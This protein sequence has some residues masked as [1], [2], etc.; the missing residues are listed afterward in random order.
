MT[1]SFPVASQVDYYGAPTPIRQLAGISVPESSSLV[2]QPYDKGSMQAIEKAIQMSDLGLPPN[3]DGKVIRLNI[4]ALTKVVLMASLRSVPH[5]T[6][7]TRSELI[8]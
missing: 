5:T 7:M 1:Q 4:P 8:W 2:I 6:C 3:N